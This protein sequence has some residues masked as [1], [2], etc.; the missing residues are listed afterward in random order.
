MKKIERIWRKFKPDRT[1]ERLGIRP[2]PSLIL[3]E[4]KR[5]LDR[6]E[7]QSLSSPLS[8]TCRSETQALR[9]CYFHLIPWNPA[10]PADHTLKPKPP[11]AS[12]LK[13]DYERLKDQWNDVEERDGARLSWNIF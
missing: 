6:Y 4:P 11:C 9:I 3:R 8:P 13:M 10:P 2:L 12:S 7:I 5:V 1:S